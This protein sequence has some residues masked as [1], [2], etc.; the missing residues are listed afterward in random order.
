MALRLTRLMALLLC[1]LLTAAVLPSAPISR[2]A[3]PEPVLPAVQSIETGSNW[4]GAYFPNRNLQGTPAFVRIDPAIVFN[5]G[6][7]SPGPSIGV[8]DWSARWDGIQFL[9]AGTYRLTV[10][11]DDG[12]RVYVNGILVID[13]WREQAPT[14]FTRDIQVT[15]GVHAFRVEYFQALGDASIS[16]S[17]Q[18]IPTQSTAWLAQYFNNPFLS[19]APVLTRLE[20]RIEHFWGLGSPDPFVVPV[21]RFSARY[22]ATLPFQAGTYRF[23]LAGDDGIRLFI[24]DLLVIDQWK[25]QSLTAYSIDVALAAGLHTIRVEYYEETEQAAVRLTINPAIGSPFGAQSDFWYGEYFANPNLSGTPTFVRN[26][27]FSGI[28]FNWN[29]SSPRPGFPRDYFSVRWTR[30]ICTPGRPTRFFIYMDDGV[31]FY[32][33]NT[34]I[35]DAWSGQPDTVHQRFVD[36]TAG[37]HDLRLEY[38]QQTLQ[39][40]IVLTWDPPDAQN[41]ALPIPNVVPGSGGRTVGANVVGIVVN[42]NLLNVRAADSPTATILEQIR[43]GSLVT[44]LA[45]NSAATWLRIRTPSGVIGWV[46]ANFIQTNLPDIRSLPVDG[47][48]GSA[49]QP[50]GVRGQLTSGLRL[51]EGPGFTFRQLTI[52]EW[53]EIVDLVGRSSD[54]Q[55]Y[56]VIY[57]GQ[58]GWIYALYVRIIQ[59]NPFSLPITG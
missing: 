10:R 40:F 22:T 3:Q 50:T 20:P 27:G 44:V 35:I 54:G 51:R 7:N 59:G 18:F 57:R 56:E 34:L 28:N 4:T 39:S 52:I 17:W 55:W 2:A 16:F 31:R 29:A 42:A 5:W 46:N 53:G 45:R 48:V 24:N 19:G 37:C 30:R 14:T 25:R 36:L 38:Q 49:P 47:T 41:P 21:E 6:Q 1:A 33:D 12:V 8:R 9:N 32:I 15:A 43:G 23:V 26:D 13:E 58:R 11:A